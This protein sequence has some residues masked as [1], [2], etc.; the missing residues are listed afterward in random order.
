MS[1]KVLIVTYYWIPSG[2][3]GVQRWLK[4]VKYLPDFGVDPVLYVPQNPHYPII[5]ESLLKEIPKNIKIYKAPIFEPYLFAGL[6]SR[7]KTDRISSGIITEK[8]Q[9]FLEKAMLWIR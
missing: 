1:K 8:N 6:V 3:P 7:K 2:G 5:D 4:F 9:S